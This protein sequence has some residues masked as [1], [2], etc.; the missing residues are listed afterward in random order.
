MQWH[1]VGHRG[2]GTV[3]MVHPLALPWPWHGY[4]GT[5][6]CELVDVKTCAYEHILP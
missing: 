2:I 3:S 5:W 1:I 4:A 6:A